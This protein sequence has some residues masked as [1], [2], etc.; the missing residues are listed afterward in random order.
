MA[1]RC[2][3]VTDVRRYAITAGGTVDITLAPATV[4]YTLRVV[5]ATF[6][7]TAWTM[8]Y[9]ANSGALVQFHFAAGE[10]YQEERIARDDDSPLVIRV[11]AAVVSTAEVIV[12]E[13]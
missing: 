12:W 8:A 3:R 13:A 9:T 2:K 11:G 1:T 6:A 10:S 5:D 7:G 4:E